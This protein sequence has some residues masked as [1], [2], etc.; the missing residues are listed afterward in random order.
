MKQIHYALLATVLICLNVHATAQSIKSGLWEISAQASISPVEEK[1][2]ADMRKQF[3]NMPTRKLFD[4]AAAQKGIVMSQDAS[5]L[6]VCVTP[7][8]A[9]RATIL[10]SDEDCKQTNIKRTGNVIKFS[11]VC[12]G[13]GEI[14]EGQNTIIS[15]IEIQSTMSYKLPE[16]P[17]RAQITK[18]KFLSSDCG[19]IRLPVTEKNNLS[20]NRMN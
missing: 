14:A 8:M 2:L 11:L 20:K 6:K 3:A 15:S 10:S 4:E 12:E 7:E 17:V 5:S 16:T 1:K 9:E 19:N 13:L 18:G